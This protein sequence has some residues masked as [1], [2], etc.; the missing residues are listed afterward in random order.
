MLRL[1]LSFTLFLLSAASASAQVAVAT[2]T[3]NIGGLAKLSFS[4]STI[5]LNDDDPDRFPVIEAPPITITAKARSGPAGLVTLTV[6]ASDDLRSGTTV[7]PAG[8]LSWVASGPGF[9]ANGTVS[10]TVPGVVA[11]WTGSGVRAGTQTYRF[12]NRWTHPSGT[13]S[14]TLL[15]TLVAP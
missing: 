15:Y 10:R 13:Y 8:M 1:G 14:L 12:Q 6:Q 11:A 9:N 7:I 5:V 2:L 4:T 3:A